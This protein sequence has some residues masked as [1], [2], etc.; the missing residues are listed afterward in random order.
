[1]SV[2][3]VKGTNYALVYSKSDKFLEGL[4]DADFASDTDDKKS[5]S[6]V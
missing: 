6:G 4:V 3:S 2:K 5:I 1:M